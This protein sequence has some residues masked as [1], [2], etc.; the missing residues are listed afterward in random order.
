V[1]FT[2]RRRQVE[3]RTFIEVEATPRTPEARALLREF[4]S[5]LRDLETRWRG[6]VRAYERANREEAKRA[7][8][9]KKA[10]AK[11][12]PAKKTAAKKAERPKR[13]R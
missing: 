2:I 4:Q 7:A 11:K 12:A 5:G 6:M 9:A 8:P 13:G 10:A 3:G 1:F